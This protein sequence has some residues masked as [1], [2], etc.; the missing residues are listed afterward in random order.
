MEH[1][2]QLHGSGLLAWVRLT[3]TQMDI[4]ASKGRTHAYVDFKDCPDDIYDDLLE[5][6]KDLKLTEHYDR[7]WK[8]SW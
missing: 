8:I 4:A 5:Y 7:I 2:G 3:F 6:L 1:T